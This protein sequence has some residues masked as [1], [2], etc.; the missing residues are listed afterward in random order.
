[1]T[2]APS[3]ADC[4][5]VALLGGPAGAIAMYAV[6]RVLNA[7]GWVKGDITLAIRNI[8]IPGERMP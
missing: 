2:M 3:T 1:M 7:A 5:K 8:F 4:L 6:V